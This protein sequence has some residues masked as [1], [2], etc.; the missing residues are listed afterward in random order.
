MQEARLTPIRSVSTRS[1][2]ALIQRVSRAAVHVD[3]R[4]VGQIG[5]GLLVF[6]GIGQQDTEQDADWL[7]QK[8]LTLRIFPDEAGKMNRSLSDVGGG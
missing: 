7:I 3:G 2:R 4:V 8:I 1:M 5:R 6:V